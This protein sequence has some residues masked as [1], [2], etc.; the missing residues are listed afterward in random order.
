V[1]AH[2]L[3]DGDLDP[4]CG[5]EV[6]ADTDLT[7]EFEDR[8]YGFCG[9]RCR[10]R[11]AADPRR[12][13]D[14]RADEAVPVPGA[15]YTCPMHP[16]VVQ[17]GPGSCPICGMALEPMVPTLDA[18]PDP[19]LVDMTRRLVWAA[20][21]T[22]PL[23]IIAMAHM[24][25]SFP[26]LLSDANVRSLLQLVLST[27]VCIWAAWPFYVRAI[28]SLST[29]NLNMFTLI[30]LGVSVA[31]GYSVVATL[32]PALFPASFRDAHGV[33][34]LYFEA[35]AVIVTLIL[36]GQ[37]LELRARGA[38]GAAI[39][40]LLGLAPT[41]ARRLDADGG[42]ADVPLDAV[43]V[44]ER[45][46]VRPGEKIPVDGVVLDG[47]SA[48]EEAMLT[49][50]AIP[51]AKAAGDKLVAGTLNGSGMLVMRAERVGRDT[52]LA[53]IVALVA[54]ASRSRA[55]LQRLADRVAAWF[56]PLV[57]GI[58]AVAFVLWATFGPEPRFAYAILNAVAVLII[59]C[60]CA[61]G[62]ATPM[63]IMVA[64]GRGAQAGILFRSAAAI[65]R[66][67]DVDTLV[68]DKTGTLT[69]GRPELASVAVLRAD[70][71]ED[72][73]VRV[74]ASLERGSEHPLAEAIV[75][76]ADARGVV[77]SE[78][79]GF[80]SSSGKGVRGRVDGRD[81]ALGNA[82]YFAEIGVAV[83][84]G[85]AAADAL[86]DAGQTVV[87]I[88]I[89]GGLAGYLGVL[90]PVKPN[91]GGALRRLRRD[92]VRVVMVT[93]DYDR[94]ARAVARLLGIDDVRAGVLPEGKAEEVRRLQAAGRVVAM[95]GDGINDAP[96]L[97]TADVGIAMGNGTDIAMET[98][99]VTLVKGDLDGIARARTLSAATVAN[100]RQNLFFAFVYNALGVPVAAGALYPAFGILLSP[101]LA[102]LAMSA[103][104][105]SVIG[106]AL[107]LRAR[108]I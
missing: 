8:V 93:G 43:V 28:D 6:D 89:D 94:T 21:F 60:P 31:Y 70:V 79:E 2:A 100:I 108:R 62:L 80:V 50:E 1:A 7:F 46:R 15:Q 106:N 48:V 52:M 24:V 101:M 53:R 78:P 26:H 40:E 30:A 73:L 47:A 77:L 90:D 91:A 54:E 68:V 37:V 25:P 57:V 44:G 42:E 103:S 45:L 85:E 63:S 39:R 87:W 35:G 59:A 38:T 88:A 99:A 17:D 5:M 16:E 14:G 83:D 102:A 104:S 49:G 81:V 27:P 65:E 19:E 23:V 74:A 95:A 32:A 86:R 66:L 4:V 22:V 67:R 3:K 69:V 11:F 107:R 84:A 41:T 98:A 56:V 96:A 12:Y 20:G 36:L 64:T 92:G 34:E 18:G 10:E 51:V 13:L 82:A 55:P 76:A 9:P 33:V 97:A 72:A 61:L 75:R 58:A 29:R 71:D 105:V